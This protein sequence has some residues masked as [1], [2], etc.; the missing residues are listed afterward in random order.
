LVFLDNRDHEYNTKNTI[1]RVFGFNVDRTKTAAENAQQILE[2][3]PQNVY[4]VNRINLAFNNL[5][6]P[7]IQLPV[8]TKLL[9]GQGLKFCI[10]RPR[11]YQDLC[12]ALKLFKKDIDLRNFLVK[13]GLNEPTPG[14]NRRLYV[15][16]RY[17]ST[18]CDDPLASAYQRFE[19]KI[20]ELRR[21][22]PTYRRFNLHPIQRRALAAFKIQGLALC[23]ATDKVLGLYVVHRPKYVKLGMEEHL[24]NSYNY[25]RLS[26]AEADQAI[27]E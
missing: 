8:G 21:A 16:S 12:T 13:E 5:C 20:N 14:F 2:D 15:N 22:L 24:S 6:P 7:H 1:H 9:L 19:N 27:R 17:V 23:Y 26:S 18:P 10:E 4:T 11:P 25:V 3:E